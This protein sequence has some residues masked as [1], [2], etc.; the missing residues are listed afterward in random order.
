[1]NLV[2]FFL[3]KSINIV[4]ELL[5]IIFIS[6]FVLSCGNAITETKQH[7]L[8]NKGAPTLILNVD[9]F[10]ANEGWKKL[11]E[12]VESLSSGGI[13]IGDF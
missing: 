13:I 11:R 8:G 1:M 2:L 3:Q 9:D 12:A 6:S 5:C 10:N 7:L 4:S